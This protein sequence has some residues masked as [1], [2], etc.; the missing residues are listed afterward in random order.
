MQDTESFEVKV[1]CLRSIGF[2]SRHTFA[3]STD[4]PPKTFMPCPEVKKYLER[5]DT[6]GGMLIDS[7]PKP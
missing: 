3:N 5:H 7:V 2:S 4:H 6:E 1:H